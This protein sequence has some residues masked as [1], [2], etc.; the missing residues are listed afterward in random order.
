MEEPGSICGCSHC[1]AL[2][3]LSAGYR[4]LGGSEP[5]VGD[6][7]APSA[8]DLENVAAARRAC[9]YSLP[10]VA[11]CAHRSAWPMAAHPDLLPHRQPLGR[12]ASEALLLVLFLYFRRIGSYLAAAGYPG[13]GSALPVVACLRSTIAARL[14][15]AYISRRG[16]RL[17]RRNPLGIVSLHGRATSV[18][19]AFVSSSVGGRSNDKGPRRDSPG[20]DPAR[21]KFG[22][23]MGLLRG[24]GPLKCRLFG[25]QSAHRH[26]R[27]STFEE[28][29][30]RRLDRRTEFRRQRT[31]VLSAQG[32][33]HTLADVG[34]IGGCGSG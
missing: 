27:C 11:D 4:R 9:G 8:F 3:T 34:R 24:K 1:P 19:A 18:S 17:S 28:R 12:A 33:S 2:Y 22:R 25:A 30:Y 26:E 15:R 5:V 29:G 6:A 23:P 20:S 31:R 13:A 7:A 32:L 14:A 21:R 10:S 16:S